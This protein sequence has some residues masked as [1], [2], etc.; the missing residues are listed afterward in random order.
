M[1]LKLAISSVAL[2]AAA[3]AAPAAFAAPP[4]GITPS[5]TCSATMSLAITGPGITVLDCSGFYN[6]N[7]NNAADFAN[8]K[9]LL[10]GS[11]GNGPLGEFPNT[12]ITSQIHI[13]FPPQA[14]ST[15]N[16]GSTI[17]G[18]AVIGIHWGGNDTAFYLIHIANPTSTFNISALNL[19]NDPPK[20]GLSNAELY[21][22]SPA[23]EPA[24]YAL[25]L[26]GLGLVS[27]MA[28]R[29]KSA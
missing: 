17:H 11:D 18:N 21:G 20:N 24:T 7:L 14:A 15:G 8:V 9:S 16:F 27:F 19:A 25:M 29:R 6:G 13:D 28:R 3:L 22:V 23:P 5:S 2:A 12:L 26:A 4:T 10:E 1:K